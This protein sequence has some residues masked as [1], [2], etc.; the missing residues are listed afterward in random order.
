[1]SKIK[2]FF[3]R[4]FTKPKSTEENSSIEETNNVRDENGDY[5]VK[6]NRNYDIIIAIASIILSIIIWLFVIG[7]K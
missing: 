4:I 6:S 2:D 7:T 3:K 5:K 1:M